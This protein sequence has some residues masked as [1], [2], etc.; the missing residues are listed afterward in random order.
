MVIITLFYFE[1]D[2][3]TILYLNTLKFYIFIQHFF[4]ILSI[5]ISLRLWMS[6]ECIFFSLSFLTMIDCML[7]SHT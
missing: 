7:I 5:F 4:Y 6:F 3:Y 2:D 1:N